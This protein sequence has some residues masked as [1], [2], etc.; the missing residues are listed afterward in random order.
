MGCGQWPLPAGRVCR[1]PVAGAPG[2]GDGRVQAPGGVLPPHLSHREPA[3]LA[4]GRGPAPRRPGW[5][6]GVQLQTNGGG[7]T[8]SM[9]AL[10]H[11]FSG[12]APSELLG[13]DSVMQ[14]AGVKTLPT[15]R[16]VVLVGNKIRPAIRSPNPMARWCARCGASWPGSSVARRP[17]SACAP[18]TRRPRAPVMCCGSFTYGP[19]L[20]LIDEWVPTRASST[21][22]A[23]CPL[24]RSRRS[25]PLPRP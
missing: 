12:T 10:Y 13:I 17:S 23:T 18:M 15:A 7:K 20:I 24:A 19:C 3:T 21:T 5:R 4:R 22:R 8:H 11:L 1:R 6:P 2:R 14:D 25:S 16:R 9:L